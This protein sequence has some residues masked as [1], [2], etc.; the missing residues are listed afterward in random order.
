MRTL[1]QIVKLALS[2]GVLLVLGALAPVKNTQ[3]QLPVPPIYLP[4]IA[5]TDL[6]HW[7]G[8]DGG[9]I[10][11][12]AADPNPDPNANLHVAYATTLGGGIF[13][14][15]NG[16]TTWSAI[17][18]GITNFWADSIAIDP[19]DPTMNTAYAG[20]H[21]TGVYKTTNGGASW[22]PKNNGIADNSVVY[23]VAVN[24][25]NHAL[26]YA[27]TRIANTTY[28]GILYKSDNGGDSWYTV[29]QYSD[30]WVYSIAVSPTQPNIVMV[31]V[32]TRGPRISK[33]Y[34]NAGTWSG[35]NPPTNLSTT[36]VQR[37]DKGRAVAFNPESGSDWAYYTAWDN[38][39]VSYSTDNGNDWNMSSGASSAQV[40]P[41]GISVK[42]NNSNIVYLADHDHSNNI[43]GDVLRSS[44]RGVSY[45]LTALTNETTYSVAALSNASDVALA[46][47]WMDGLWKTDNGGSSWYRSMAGITNSRVTGFA[48]PG[49]STIYGSTQSGGGVFKST[50]GGATWSVFSNNWGD[51]VVNGLVLNPHDPNILFALTQSTGLRRIT[52]STGGWTTAGAVPIPFAKTFS[53]TIARFAPLP[54]ANDLDEAPRMLVDPTA[55]GTSAAMLSMEFAPSNYNIAYVGTAGGGVYASTDNGVTFSQV[56][57]GGSVVQGLGVDPA[58]ASIVYAATTQAGVLKKSTDGGHNWSD[59]PLP[60]SSVVVNTVAVWPIDPTSVYI[61]TTNGIYRY[62]GSA[63]TQVALPGVPVGELGYNPSLPSRLFAGTNLGVYQASAN[64]TYWSP[65]TTLMT[66]NVVVSL[67]FNPADPT[68]VYIGSDMRGAVVVS[69]P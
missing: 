25:G 22:Q 7:M 37:W 60:D 36:D 49:G 47:T 10:I 69:L 65:V 14:S 9:S 54:V 1:S 12:I 67:S 3:A 64:G 18:N 26:V 51:R 39:K 55:I 30:D 35:V 11:S 6:G 33:D 66:G 45:A 68:R 20:T 28:T 4:I 61:G 31:A 29:L 19:K 48:F 56:G 50:D 63:W 32:H 53:S 13:K 41:N 58:N 59:M 43:P 16:G 57:L 27:A 34:G 17:N 52:L 24:P 38:G 5:N 23:A 62:S 44:D 42:P 40:Y 15:S 46:G 21:G 8:P 2:L